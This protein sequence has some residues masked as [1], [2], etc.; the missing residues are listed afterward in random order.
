M[1]AQKKLVEVNITF[2]NTEATDALTKYATEKIRSC[3]QKFTH[4]DVVV[5]VVL[6]IE[7]TRHIAEASFR[8]D[9]ADFHCKEDSNDLYKS[10]DQLVDTISEQMRRHKEKIKVRH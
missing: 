2:R 6:K 1:S 4:H 3:I 9:N 5:D 10:I 7:K 8:T